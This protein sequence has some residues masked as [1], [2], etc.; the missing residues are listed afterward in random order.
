MKIIKNILPIIILS[1]LFSITEATAQRSGVEIWGQTC[2][3]CHSMQPASRYTA[4][5]WE[6]VMLHMK[7]NARLSDKESAA[8]LEYLKFGASDATSV[9]PRPKDA[10]DV[11]AVGATE[12]IIIESPAKTVKSALSAVEVEKIQEFINQNK[13]VKD[14]KE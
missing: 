10:I 14:G 6:S 2:G 9:E 3:N 5:K 4:K 13:K 7:I 1:T 12:T 8:V 11:E